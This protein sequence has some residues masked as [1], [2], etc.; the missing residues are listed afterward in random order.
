MIKKFLIGVLKWG[1]G[2][3]LLALLVLYLFQ[4]KIIFQ[5]TALPP[6]FRFSFD[7]KFI[8]KEYTTKDGTTLSTLFFPSAGKSKGLVF[9]CHGN[10]RNLK[11]WGRFAHNFTKNGY[12][13]FMWDYRGFGKSEGSPSENNIFDDAEMLYKLMREKYPESRIIAYGRS[14]GSG[15]ATYIASKNSPRQ[16]I[17]ETPYLHMADV[18]FKHFPFIPYNLLIKHPFRTDKYI[19]K[20][21]C[22]INIFHGTN[23]ELVP[24]ESSLDLAQILNK[25][26]EELVIS[27]PGGGHRGLERYDLYQEKLKQLLKN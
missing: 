22:P 12:D 2:F 4:D 21:N 7:S 8:E 14:L 23:D 15:V 25:S 6:D 3:Y 10:R 11:T 13:V 16:L 18:G 20:V 19:S 26:P 24:Y 27:I 17:L 5:A 1:V 9:Y